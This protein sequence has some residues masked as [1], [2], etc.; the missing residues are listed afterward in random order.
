M[1]YWISCLYWWKI[2]TKSSLIIFFHQRFSP[3]SSKSLIYRHSL[4]PCTITISAMLWI[5]L[6]WQYNQYLSLLN[7]VAILAFSVFRVYAVKCE[8]IS[9][10]SK[11]RTANRG[12]KSPEPPIQIC[13]SFCFRNENFDVLIIKMSFYVNFS[14]FGCGSIYQNT[15]YITPCSPWI[16]SWWITF[17]CCIETQTALPGSTE[18]PN[19]RSMHHEMHSVNTPFPQSALMLHFVCFRTVAKYRRLKIY[20]TTIIL[21]MRDNCFDRIMQKYWK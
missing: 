6:Q 8:E 11:I 2:Q 21:G 14:G 10:R 15:I 13:F 3:L 20:S 5:P 18:L 17:S 7:A 12:C 4:L 9:P 19:L 16:R 1:K